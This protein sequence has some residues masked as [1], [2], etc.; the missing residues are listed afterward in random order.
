MPAV[1]IQIVR[2]APPL[3][4]LLSLKA[5]KVSPALITSPGLQ[6]PTEIGSAIRNFLS[7]DSLVTNAVSSIATSHIAVHTKAPLS[8]S[9]DSSTTQK[10]PRTTT[11]ALPQFCTSTQRR[12]TLALKNKYE[13][14]FRHRDRSR[15]Q[16]I[17]CIDGS[18]AYTERSA[19]HRTDQREKLGTR[20]DEVFR[21]V[22]GFYEAFFQLSSNGL[23]SS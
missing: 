9:L 3:C 1:W 10:S 11:A 23:N 15:G 2:N 6:K 8:S 14:E 19:C 12:M 4:L 16:P 21:I 18:S 20:T 5:A 17:R 13:I 7:A 22:A